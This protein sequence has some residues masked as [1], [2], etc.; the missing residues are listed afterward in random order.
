MADAWCAAFVWRKCGS[1]DDTIP[2]CPTT[3]TLEEIREKPIGN[4]VLVAREAPA[5]AILHGAGT[6]AGEVAAAPAES[7]ADADVILGLL[8]VVESILEEEEKELLYSM[9][10]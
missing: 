5:R 2:P 6:E 1:P 7:G 8:K 3:A 4:E 10:L 9:I